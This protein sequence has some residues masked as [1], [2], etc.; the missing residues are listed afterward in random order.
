VLIDEYDLLDQD[1]VH[2][3]FTNYWEQGHYK[4]YD[5]SKGSLRNWIAHYVNLYLNHVIRKY[6]I[7]A[8]NDEI[9]NADPLDQGNRS[10][11]V[12][13][14][15]DNIRDDPDYQ[16][17]FDIDWTNPES[18]LI[19]KETLEFIK[20]HFSEIE[21][22]HLMGEIGLDE[23]ARQAG[24]SCEAFRRKLD[25]RIVDFKMALKAIERN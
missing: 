21:I 7:R 20:G 8:R 17:E 1:I 10:N 9:Q 15:E 4:K 19:A 5:G 22:E 12:S 11:I 16:P 3:L 24:T 23:A 14:D 2:E 18:S 6:A 13:I 25:R